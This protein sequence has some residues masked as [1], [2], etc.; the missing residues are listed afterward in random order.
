MDFYYSNNMYFPKLINI[1]NVTQICGSENYTYFL[2]NEGHIYFCGYIKDSLNEISMK[3][4]NCETKF[5]SLHSNQYNGWTKEYYPTAVSEN[6]VYYLKSNEIEKTVYKTLFDF[7]SNEYQIT[8]KTISMRKLIFEKFKIS[9]DEISGK[10]LNHILK[11]ENNPLNNIFCP[12]SRDF[13]QRLKKIHA[14]SYLF[15]VT[16]DDEVFCSIKYSSE[17][18]K[19]IPELCD[20]NIKQFFIGFDFYLV[21]SCDNHLFG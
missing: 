4:L 6:C 3:L 20:K 10:L 2:T 12:L 15:C 8:Y 17:E 11:E 18:P 5:I 1:S 7:Y 13:K 19:L 9:S 14:S 21:I 16:S